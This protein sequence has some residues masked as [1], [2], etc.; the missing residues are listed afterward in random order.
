MRSWQGYQLPGIPAQTRTGD[1]L[2]RSNRP[3]PK[4]RKWL[5][6]FPDR[7]ECGCVRAKSAIDL[8]M[9]ASTGVKRIEWMSPAWG[10]V[11]TVA[12]PEICPRSLILL[13]LIM[14]RPES[15]GISVFRS[16]RTWF[17]Q[18]KPPDQLKPESKVLPTT[19]PLLLMPVALEA[20]SPGRM[21]RTVSVPSGCQREIGTLNSQ[22]LQREGSAV[23]P[24]YGVLRC[25]AVSR[26]AHCLA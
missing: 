16:V 18:I 4:L 20:L 24:H 12:I 19:W 7:L 15:S 11:T 23:L 6:A 17:C 8:P 21:P 3:G 22:V 5:H 1:T 2:Y 14:R 10:P 26:V 13:A 25:E 9:L